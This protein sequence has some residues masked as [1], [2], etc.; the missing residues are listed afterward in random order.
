MRC[1]GRCRCHESSWKALDQ[2]AGL[3][4]HTGG[5]QPY[6]ADAVQFKQDLKEK[7]LAAWQKWDYAP[8]HRP[9]QL[10][11]AE[12]GFHWAWRTLRRTIN[13]LGKEDPEITWPPKGLGR[14]LPRAA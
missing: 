4:R 13:R 2:A 5:R 12:Y 6:A 8:E 10:E 1:S 14:D 11:V 3:R 7:Y 9:S